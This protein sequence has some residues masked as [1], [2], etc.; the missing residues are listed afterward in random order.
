MLLCASRSFAGCSDE[1][2]MLSEP[3]ESGDLDD[4]YDTESVGVRAYCKEV[5]LQL[6]ILLYCSRTGLQLAVMQ[7]SSKACQQAFAC[8]HS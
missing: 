5:T 2:V 4:A 3:S 1:E 6:L 7:L 8:S